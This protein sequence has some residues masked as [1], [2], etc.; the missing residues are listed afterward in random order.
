MFFMILLT[1]IFTFFDENKHYFMIFEAPLGYKGYAEKMFC[2]MLK[3]LSKI[4]F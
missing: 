2:F 3:G 4:D 1:E